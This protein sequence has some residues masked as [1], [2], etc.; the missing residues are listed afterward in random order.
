LLPLHEWDFSVTAERYESPYGRLLEAVP[1][2]P[3]FPPI[4]FVS[5]PL[6]RNIHRTRIYASLHETLDT[7]MRRR[8]SRCAA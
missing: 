4:Q 6:G 3:G 7:G 1:L 8:I 5:E 2:A